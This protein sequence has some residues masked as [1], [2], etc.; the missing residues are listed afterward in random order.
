MKKTSPF[1]NI[2]AL[3]VNA[4]LEKGKVAIVV[5]ARF[6]D[7]RVPEA[8]RGN[9]I[10][11]NL[12][13]RFPGK[14]LLTEEHVE[15]DLRFGGVSFSVLVPWTRV[16]AACTPTKT[17]PANL[18]QWRSPDDVESTVPPAPRITALTVVPD[19]PPLAE[20]EAREPSAPRRGAGGCACGCRHLRTPCG[21][22]DRPARGSRGIAGVR[23]AGAPQRVLETVRSGGARGRADGVLAGADLRA[24]H[25]TGNVPQGR[26]LE[27]RT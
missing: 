1:K 14:M 19:A 3:A 15:A 24:R 5:D 25:G 2:K 17:V 8:V 21:P 12:S 20:G 27:A 16:Y 11:L 22:Q 26:G 4:L 6:P 23:A 9:I 18:M 13:W 10:T 7:V